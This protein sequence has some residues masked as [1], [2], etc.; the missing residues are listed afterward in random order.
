VIG[1]PDR[2]AFGIDQP[3][4]E[5]HP[6]ALQPPAVGP[7][8]EVPAAH[9]LAEPGVDGDLQQAQ[10]G[11]PPEQVSTE[12]PLG[13]HRVLGGDRQVDG[14]G[15]GQLLGD[16]EPRV[17]ASDHQHRPLR[18]GLGVAVV[19]AVDLGHRG[20]QRGGRRWDE[21]DLERAGGHHHL[22]GPVGGIGGAD[23]EVVADA[24]QVCDPGVEP[25][26]QVEG[27][28]VGLQVAGHRVLGRVG[29]GRGREGHAGQG[30]VLGRGEQ[31]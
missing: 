24:P 2:A 6:L 16:L 4:P 17:A 26:G 21:R 14:A 19:G 18:E 7:D 13:Q 29:V 1:E 3:R 8:H 30:V 27:G 11:Q 22:P 25:D 31:L 12:T 5:S 28:R 9:P 20:V 15:G 10:P 23:L